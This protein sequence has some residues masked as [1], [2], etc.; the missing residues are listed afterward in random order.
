MFG[1][2]MFLRYFLVIFKD[3]LFGVSNETFIWCSVHKVPPILLMG[4]DVRV[5]AVL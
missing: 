5:Y 3:V 1:L 2:P 4:W